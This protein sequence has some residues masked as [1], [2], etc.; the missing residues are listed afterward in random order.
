MTNTT[1]KSACVT[2]NP[3]I[4]GFACAIK[5]G[6]VDSRTVALEITG[7]DCGQIKKLS[8]RLTRLLL[9]EMFAPISRN[10]VYALAEQSGCHLSCP[11]PVAVIKAAE[12]A[13]G[14]ALPRDVQIR[15]DPCDG[16]TTDAG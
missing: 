8:E 14:I 9:N 13:F 1:P 7:S 2:V 10:P 11:I 3:G 16:S 5:A 6:K 15:F 4:C 12:A